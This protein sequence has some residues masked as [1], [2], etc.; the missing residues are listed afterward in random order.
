MAARA[1][2]WA[3]SDDAVRAVIVYGSLA[4]GTPDKQSDLD[5]IV[6]AEPGKGDELWQQRE[7]ISAL[8]HGRQPAWSQEPRWQRPYRCKLRHGESWLV[9]FGVMDTLNNRVLPLLGA[10]SHSAHSQLDPADINRIQQAA[11]ASPEP[12]ALHRSLRAAATLYA[13]ALDRWS[14][15]TGLPRPRH[16]LAPAI[17]DRLGAPEW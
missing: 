13:W 4:Q 14:E 10:A 3:G 7:H 9:R 16:P 8:L 6:V 5:L 15:R 1:A 12:A 17:M 11:P 2:A